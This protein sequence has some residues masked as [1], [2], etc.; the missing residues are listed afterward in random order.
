[1]AEVWRNLGLARASITCGSAIPKKSMPMSLPTSAHAPARRFLRL[2]LVGLSILFTVATGRV[3]TQPSGG[4]LADSAALSR[5][6]DSLI[7]PGLE[8]HHIPGLVLVV[9]RDS[10]VMFERGYGYAD[11]ERRVPFN[12]ESTV[13]RIA[14]ISKLFTGTA[15]MQLV[16]QGRLDLHTDINRYL[17]RF[18]VEEW[19][20]R[21]VTLHALLT[22][23][24]GFDDRAIGK[25]ARTQETQV[26][27]G[28][29]L[30]R[31]LPPLIMPPGEVYT[32]SN[33]SN[34]LAGLV[35]EEA[36]HEDYAAYVRSR[37]LLPL[38]M[39]HSDYRLRR[40]LAPLLTRS[41]S[42]DGAGYREHAFDFINDYPGGQMLSTGG[43]MA[44][45]M[46][47]HLGLGS[48]RGRR[49]LSEESA[50]RM[51]AP[52]FSHHPMLA[53]AVGYSFHIG[54]F[55]GDT[56]LMH[57]G[58]YPGVASRLCLFPGRH[59]G[60]FMACNIMD[61]SLIT[62]VSVQLCERLIP[63]PSPDTT[64]YPLVVLPAYDPGVDQFAGVY[65]FS[66]YV[67]SGI[68]KAGLVLGIGG[69]EMRI[70]RTQD[71]MILMN[72]LAGTPRR[73]IQTAPGVFRSIDDAYT[74][75][76]RRDSGGD[77]THLFTDGTTALE[78]IA[79]YETVAFQRTLFL[80]CMGLFALVAI[81]LPVARRVRRAKGPAGAGRNSLR[82]LSE[83]T[84]SMFLFYV[85]AAGLVMGLAV[86]REELMM[87]FPYG[88]PWAMYVVQTLPILGVIL[89]V[90]L[91]ISL[92]RTFVRSS[93]PTAVR[94]AG[95][96]YVAA[97]TALAGVAFLWF[98]ATWNLIGYR[99]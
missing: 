35:V 56:I 48:L 52:Q 5:F 43:D 77:I 38:G 59:I 29:F 68:E 36:V 63:S 53:G 60:L 65:R 98:L 42:Y 82:R 41:Y 16:E 32:Y 58:G 91:I 69:F 51:H 66:R 73:M 33:L 50:R 4:L 25:S 85:L 8:R 13:I 14:S 2:L 19:P 57:D 20:G 83:M 79:W 88:M 76:C 6:L 72:T 22:H 81:V 34:A 15:V 24:A 31:R 49:I 39:L 95:T 90:W 70:G 23:T 78:K 89:L 37:I 27:L 11:L 94:A 96:G 99:F 67:H 28:D 30:A 84:A 54:S 74:C 92:I 45:F 18:Q 61:N 9:V 1:M 93:N 86:P 44:K 7:V 64:I 62:E 21:P 71:G 80:V 12:P 46:M 87:G 97:A 26:P 3:R 17:T 75:T 10:N 47:A 40:D 55:R